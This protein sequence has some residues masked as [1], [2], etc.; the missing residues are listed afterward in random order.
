MESDEWVDPGT[1]EKMSVKCFLAR[2]SE[3]QNQQYTLSIKG[4]LGNDKQ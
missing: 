2:A 4:M 3:P 1:T